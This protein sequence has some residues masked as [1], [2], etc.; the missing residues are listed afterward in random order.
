M[1]KR[2]KVTIMNFT[3]LAWKKWSCLQWNE[4]AP[5]RENTTNQ[6]ILTQQWNQLIAMESIDKY[7]TFSTGVVILTDT[8]LAA[9]PP[10]IIS[11][12]VSLTPF[13]VESREIYHD[14]IREITVKFRFKRGAL[15][16]CVFW[17]S[18]NEYS[19]ANG[20]APPYSPRKIKWNYTHLPG[21]DTTQWTT[22]LDL[23]ITS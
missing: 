12:V 19:E 5:E 18:V 20:Q 4:A 21:Q 11:I 1:Q 14:C 8:L 3:G 23:F 13:Y 7:W 15:D 22:R 6:E 10:P 2:R 9:P 16:L 17:L